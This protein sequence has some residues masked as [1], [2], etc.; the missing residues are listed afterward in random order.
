MCV[1]RKENLEQTA[2]KIIAIN[3]AL[4]SEVLHAFKKLSGSLQ[5]I[6]FATES[7]R[8]N[9]CEYFNQLE[10]YLLNEAEPDA[11]ALLVLSKEVASLAR[12]LSGAA[13][14][15]KKYK[16]REEEREREEQEERE[17]KELEDAQKRLDLDLDEC[18]FFI[19]SATE[20]YR[21]II[22]VM[23]GVQ[24]NEA[25]TLEVRRARVEHWFF[26]ADWW[27]KEAEK[28][29]EARPALKSVKDGFY[30]D[31]I[32][33]KRDYLNNKAPVVSID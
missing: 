7:L 1:T 29:L 30:S 19:Q 15:A 17:K 21:F 23:A 33:E 25:D 5:C 27:L 24:K 10:E 8:E 31:A 6:V 3:D 4:N 12:K 16:E 20:E 13:A 28:E 14:N 2:D 18:D 22:D 11:A 9:G 32:R 26:N